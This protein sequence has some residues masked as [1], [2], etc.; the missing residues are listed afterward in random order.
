MNITSPQSIL[1]QVKSIKKEIK[2]DDDSKGSYNLFLVLRL[3]SKELAHS[4][5]IADLLNPNAKHEQNDVFLKLFL[6]TLDKPFNCDKKNNQ[7]SGFA[8]EKATS[9]V[10]DHIGAVNLDDETGG[11]IDILIDDDDSKIIIEN[12]IYAP[13]QSKQLVR[14]HNA[15]PNAPILYLTLDGKEP[16]INSKGDL[17]KGEDFACISYQE[18]IISWIENCIN[19]MQDGLR[20]KEF[21]KQYLDIVKELIMEFRLRDLILENKES[22]CA[23]KS[24]AKNFEKARD[25]A[26]D[27]LFNGLVDMGN[28]N[29][30]LEGKWK[31]N[32]PIDEKEGVFESKSYKTL[33]I[34]KSGTSKQLYFYFRHHKTQNQTVIGIVKGKGVKETTKELVESLNHKPNIKTGKYSINYEDLN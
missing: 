17:I 3:E 27:E 8:T 29:A 21:L 31:W 33:L 15:Y 12:K 26:I 30:D 13:D 23:A 11:N 1:E 9:K 22:Y 32:L 16:D 14:Y 28:E 4:N 25:N 20:I 34:N 24:I 19:E 10:E 5:F 2:K 18:H 7:L 6:K